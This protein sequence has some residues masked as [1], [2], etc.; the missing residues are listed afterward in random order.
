MYKYGEW[1]ISLFSDSYNQAVSLTA[2]HISFVS[3]MLD[4]NTHS[5]SRP[6]KRV[7]IIG[8][9]SAGIIVA[10]YMKEAGFEVRV[11]ERNEAIGGTWYCFGVKLIS[12]H[13]A[14]SLSS[15]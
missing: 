2:P 5:L 3:S 11:F 8:A 13:G 1:L 6:V 12:Y 4:S 10:K 7:A 9:G 14:V 15:D